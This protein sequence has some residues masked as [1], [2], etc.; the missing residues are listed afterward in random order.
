MTRP[1]ISKA[2]VLFTVAA[3]VGATFGSAGAA[4]PLGEIDIEATGGATSGFSA[5]AG[6][7]AITL[8]PDGNMWFL[9]R[10]E[11]AV[12]R[13]NADGTVSEFDWPIA[14]G[15]M[16]SIVAGPDGNLWFLDFNPP[17]RVGRVTPAGVVTE[18][19]TGGIT[20]GLT[21]GNL[22]NIIVG[23]DGNLW[24][25]RPFVSAGVARIT[26]AGVVTEFAAPAGIQPRDIAVGSDGNMYVTSDDAAGTILRVTSAG[27]VTTV[28]TGGV[29]PG[30]T[31]G[32]FPSD[33]ATGPD[34]ALWFLEQGGVARIT[35]SGTVTEYL[36]P[37]ATPFLTDIT[38]ACGSLWISQG[39]E[40]GSDSALLQVTTAGAFTTFTTG[41]PADSSPD[42]VAVGPD[43]DV[44]FTLR[45]DPGQVGHIGAGCAVEPPAEPTGP[46]ASPVPASPSFTG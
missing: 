8:G 11:I 40:D 18:V 39:E 23:P 10:S 9:E 26:T 36:A 15:S 7:S 46:P 38:S 17:G 12:A 2:S 29:T 42:G 44:W 14:T 21:A 22:Q 6:P 3:I 33:I 20:P 45:A 34:G 1:A 25:T 31:A 4:T 19:A 28:A 30:F 27:V 5:D 35:T 43:D 37:T 24:A 41:L 32:R 16:S 13:R